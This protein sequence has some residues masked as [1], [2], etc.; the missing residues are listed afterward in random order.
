[1]GYANTNNRWKVVRMQVCEVIRPR[2]VAGSFAF[3]IP[4]SAI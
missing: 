3:N 4:G 2:I 1:M